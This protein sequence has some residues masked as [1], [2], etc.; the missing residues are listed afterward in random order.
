MKFMSSKDGGESQSMHPNSDNK[1]IMIG[2][3][4]HEIIG[5]LFN[6]TLLHRYQKKGLEQSMKDNDFEFEYVDALHYKC[7]KSQPRWILYKFS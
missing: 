7:R 6:L 2:V 5:Q 4:P 1:E 3:G